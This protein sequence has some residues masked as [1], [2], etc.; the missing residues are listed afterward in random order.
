MLVEELIEQRFN[1]SAWNL[2]MSQFLLQC[3]YPGGIKKRLP[4]EK[5]KLN[6]A[7]VLRWKLDRL[8]GTDL[9]RLFQELLPDGSGT[10]EGFLRKEVYLLLNHH[11]PCFGRRSDP[12]RDRSV[13]GDTPVDAQSL[14]KGSKLHISLWVGRAKRVTSPHSTIALTTRFHLPVIEISIPW[15]RC[16]QRLKGRA[17]SR[18]PSAFSEG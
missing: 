18:Q 3:F 16:D 14:S 11:G 13:A 9:F 5:A 8:E 10:L 12:L 4:L 2:R 15:N 17:L 1:E 7:G 6:P